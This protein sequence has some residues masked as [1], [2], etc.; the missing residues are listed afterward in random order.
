MTLPMARDLAQ[1]GIRVMTIAPGI[2]ETPMLAGM[3]EEVQA[4]LAAAVPFPS[5]LGTAEE[6]AR[7]VV[8]IAENAMLNGETI[9]LDG[10]ETLRIAYRAPADASA[11]QW[12]SPEQTKGG[13][14]PF[15]FS[16]GQ[17]ILNRSLIPTQ[18]SP[19][20]RQTW[21][22]RITAPEPLDVVMSGVRQGEPEDLG[23]GRRAFRFVMD[24]PVPPYLIAIAAGDIDFAPIGPRT[25]VWA[26]PA[27]LPRARA[28]VGDTE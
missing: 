11:L 14:H 15:L 6:Y 12:L 4:S 10:A 3:P 21:E 1:T 23:N 18:D 27:T 13:V 2:F 17:A 7:L 25:G 22:A 20:I 24:K 28:E 8:H 16:Q 9:R 5:R 26:E 19:G